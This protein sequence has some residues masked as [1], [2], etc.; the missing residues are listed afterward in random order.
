VGVP[1]PRV[2]LLVAWI[3]GHKRLQDSS[4]KTGLTVLWALIVAVALY[5]Y[6]TYLS[7]GSNPQLE[8]L[9]A[10]RGIP[11]AVVK[12]ISQNP[13]PST[14]VL[15]NESAV[16]PPSLPSAHRPAPATTESAADWQKQITEPAISINPYEARANSPGKFTLILN[17]EGSSD[18]KSVEVFSDVLT[19]VHNNPLK[20]LRLG[21]YSK[22]TNDDVFSWEIRPDRLTG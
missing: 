21:S 18:V 7:P 2:A 12:K 1:S 4:H 6:G 17:N 19:L 8:L 10:I 5:A 9:S 14:N 20:M 13:K 11:D 22:L 3:A 16:S 15:N